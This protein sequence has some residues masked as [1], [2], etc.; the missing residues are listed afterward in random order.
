ML[1]SPRTPARSP[2]IIGSPYFLRDPL[3]SPMHSVLAPDLD[4][5]KEKDRGRMPETYGSICTTQWSASCRHVP[6]PQLLGK[7]AVLGPYYGPSQ[8]FLSYPL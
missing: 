2:Q 4:L 5:Y 1:P 8:E 6:K 7:L 3:L